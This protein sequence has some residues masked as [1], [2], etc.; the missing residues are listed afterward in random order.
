MQPSAGREQAEPMSIGVVAETG[1][2]HLLSAWCWSE[3][4]VLVRFG[5]EAG[6]A[7]GAGGVERTRRAGTAVKVIS[8]LG[9]NYG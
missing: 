7:G 1:R 5:G 8:L 3:G 9:K 2:P 6:G 4:F